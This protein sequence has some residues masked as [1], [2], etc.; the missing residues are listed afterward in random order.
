MGLG[1]HSFFGGRR[2]SNTEN[3]NEYIAAFGELKKL[4]HKS[5]FVEKQDAMEEF[6]FLGLRVR[7]GIALAAFQQEFGVPAYS[8]FGAGIK[9]MKEY[10]L[11][12]ENGGRLFLTDNGIN[13]SNRVFTEIFTRK[14]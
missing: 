8:V 2:F 9:K 14:E 13:L 6:F 11:L 5:V 1:A 7:E 4:R 3:M 10:N 12:R